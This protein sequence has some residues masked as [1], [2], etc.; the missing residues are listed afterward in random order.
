MEDGRSPSRILLSKPGLKRFF[1]RMK[2]NRRQR[3]EEDDVLTSAVKDWLGDQDVQHYKS[4]FKDWQSEG[5]SV[6]SWK[7]NF[8]KKK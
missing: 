8:L 3:P 4:G 2:K 5:T 7:G 6:W 1:P